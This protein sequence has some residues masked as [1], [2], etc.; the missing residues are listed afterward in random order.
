[1]QRLGP[2]RG[3]MPPGGA[4]AKW[5]LPIYGGIRTFVKEE[6]KLTVPSCHK[7]NSV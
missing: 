7:R 6:L 5:L 4:V 1:M 2:A 3:T